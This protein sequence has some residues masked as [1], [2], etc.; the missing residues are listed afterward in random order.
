[1]LRSVSTLLRSSIAVER[2]LIGSLSR[3]DYRRDIIGAHLLLI[4]LILAA[5]V[6]GYILP[7]FE[8]RLPTS[9]WPIDRY[10]LSSLGP[11]LLQRL[12]RPG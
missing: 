2:V 12:L 3:H 4:Q 5:L 7:D 11:C 9:E 1:M 10:L 6:A 8:C